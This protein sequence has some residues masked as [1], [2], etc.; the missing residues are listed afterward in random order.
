MC[1][2]ARRSASEASNR[3]FRHGFSPRRLNR[4]GLGVDIVEPPLSEDSRG[5]T[6]IPKRAS[7]RRFA[8]GGEAVAVDRGVVMNMP[9]KCFARWTMRAR[10]GERPISF[11]GRGRSANRNFTSVWCLRLPPVVSRLPCG[12]ERID[13][14]ITSRQTEGL[15]GARCGEPDAFV[16]AAWFVRSATSARFTNHV[17]SFSCFL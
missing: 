15:G 6:G 4:L 1:R 8:L 3:L 10:D 16:D 14:L 11:T 17:A 7:E 12:S 5:V 13:F 9:S 2:P